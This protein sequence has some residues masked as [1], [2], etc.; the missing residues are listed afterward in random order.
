VA[1][2]AHYTSAP[3]RPDGG[4]GGFQF[5][6][7]SA[8][9]RDALTTLRPLLVYVPPPGA[10]T[11]PGPEEL[12]AFPVSFAYDIVGGAGALAL[13]RYV[14]Q[15]YTGRY[16]NYFGQ[17]VL[18]SPDELV[19]VRPVELWGAP[20]WAPA[21]ALD[22][23]PLP[24]LGELRPGS[25]VS[26]DR[27]LR[28]FRK[29]GASGIQLLEQLLEAVLGT[30]DGGVGKGVL[31]S[32]G[33]SAVSQ[34][35][36]VAADTET[37]VDWLA[38]VS[39]ALPAPLAAKLTF[40][41]Y[42]DRPRDARQHIVGTVPEAWERGAAGRGPVFFLDRLAREGGSELWDRAS[43]APRLL[44]QAWAEDDVDLFDTLADIWDSVPPAGPAKPGPGSG[45]YR[46][47][48][49]PSGGGTQPWPQPTRGA[50]G[51]AGPTP[52]PAPADRKMR[53]P[54][55]G[56]SWEEMSA[57]ERRRAAERGGPDWA[58]AADGERHRAERPR[59][60]AATA[61][62][63]R[64]GPPGSLDGVGVVRLRAA[65]ALVALARGGL[66]HEPLGPAE[67]KALET[68]LDRFAGRGELLPESVHQGL[69]EGP[70]GVDSALAARLM[71]VSADYRDT[72]RALIVGDLEAGKLPGGPPD[73]ALSP[74]A[75]FVNGAVALR[76][77]GIAPA[78]VRDA[79]A[80]WLLKRP[81]PL[82]DVLARL[83]PDGARPSPIGLTEP[84]RKAV[85][86]GLLGALE[87]SA[88]LRRATL[89]THTCELLVR[90]PPDPLGV[91]EGT[92]P[93]SEAP[94]TAARVLNFGTGDDRV[95]RREAGL[96]LLRLYR[97]GLL[98]DVEAY[99]AVRDMVMPGPPPAPPPAPAGASAEE[100]EHRG[101]RGGF[102]RRGRPGAE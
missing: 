95:R 80:N 34:V 51:G 11:R 102:W 49:Q 35:F 21:P 88:T 73:T 89:D 30:L 4:Q 87:S 64:A 46:G 2:Q 6:A 79:A 41:T 68:L 91:P 85:L 9:A 18:A 74:L 40:T 33:G 96:R 24:E 37:V 71:A 65:C 76:G 20:L 1:G 17:V 27:V 101:E 54:L 99:D 39:F 50:P 22:G 93:W 7:V 59:P 83:L 72:A 23:R 25:A 86:S 92:D 69:S 47:E 60:S 66:S 14:G 78:K 58:A 29:T 26:P 8:G 81:A 15:D 98:T 52:P 62:A 36:L 94:R 75:Q 5:T 31:R 90:F 19:G 45:W 67:R 44:A 16:G 48:P 100:P 42:T 53:D 97:R 32:D 13:C 84:F 82:G 3:P 10:P 55:T 38:A 63:D 57:D 12:A 56:R 28:L 77:T 70:P 61:P 43:R